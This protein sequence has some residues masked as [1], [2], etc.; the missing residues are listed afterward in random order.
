[1][2][3]LIGDLQGCCDAFERLLAEIGYSP[4][5]DQLYLLGDLV[6]RGPESLRTLERIASFGASAQAVLGN[7]DLHLLAVA[8]GVR[9]PGKH[10]TLAGVLNAPSR[11]HWLHWLRHQ[12]MALHAH[13]WLMVHAGVLP[14]WTLAQTLA[15]AEEVQAVL[16]GPDLNTFLHQ[17]YANE[18]AR[19]DAQ[20]HGIERQRLVVNALTRL[21]FCSADGSMD[22][23]VKE[24]ATATPAGLMPWFDVPG[25]LT[26]DTPI[27]FGHWST[28]GPLNRPHLL[29][30]DTGCVWGG[31]LTAARI[32]PQDPRQRE[33]I[34]VRCEQAQKPG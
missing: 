24:A 11:E 2:I 25:R 27:A 12:H 1:M 3:Y 9:K 34:S 17:M 20:L 4:S 31:A 21:R 32:D 8:A 5:R 7:H 28:L 6:N 13:G 19:W 30:L 18:P 26:A 15:L 10:D 23:K 16:Q 33:L 29:A 14:Q 22:F